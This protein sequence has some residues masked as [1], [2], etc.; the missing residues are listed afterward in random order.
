MVYR[1]RKRYNKRYGNRYMTK[2]HVAN[3]IKKVLPKREIKFTDISQT[4]QTV[5][6]DT[7]R[8][9]CLNAVAQGDD[10]N[11][12]TGRK[13]YGKTLQL[14]LKL[15]ANP[16]QG[17]PSSVT[18][19]LIVIDKSNTNSDPT[20]A[21]VLQDVGTQSTAVYSSWNKVT[22]PNRF[23]ILYDKIIDLQELSKQCYVVNIKRKIHNL[24][25][26]Y[27]GTAATDEYTNAIYLLMINDAL[28]SST[29]EPSYSFQSRISF[30][31]D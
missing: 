31:D 8:V 1:K 18:R 25:M 3:Y 7:E 26:S 16:S 22:V 2:S 11:N 10:Y 28:D 29:D 13:I 9:H 6:F 15:S 24:V 23:G 20:V 30:Y 21:N 5:S 27:V 12:R 17:V 4:T 14:R 19:V